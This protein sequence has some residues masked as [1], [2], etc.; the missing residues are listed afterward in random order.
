MIA[1][2]P[3]VSDL[4]RTGVDRYTFALRRPSP[5]PLRALK[6]AV[7]CDRVVVTVSVQGSSAG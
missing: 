4:V 5:M 6:G 7:S 2:N 1:A 3:P